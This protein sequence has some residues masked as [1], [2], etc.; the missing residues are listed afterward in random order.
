M[1][2]EQNVCMR[3]KKGRMNMKE[4][5]KRK[6]RST[7]QEK[8]RQKEKEKEIEIYREKGTHIQYLIAVIAMLFT[9]ASFF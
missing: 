7:K 8:D 4:I 1:K 5:R 3:R 2:E 6:K 9:K